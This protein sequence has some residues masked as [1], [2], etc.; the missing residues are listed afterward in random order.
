MA[1][2]RMVRAI[3]DADLAAKVYAAAQADGVTVSTYV[4]RLLVAAVKPKRT[5]KTTKR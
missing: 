3:V 1:E 5:R 2:Q 4:E